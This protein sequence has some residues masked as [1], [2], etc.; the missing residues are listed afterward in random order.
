M[1]NIFQ[2]LVG[3]GGGEYTNI[4][5]LLYYFLSFDKHF[6]Y[7]IL[8]MRMYKTKPVDFEVALN[9]FEIDAH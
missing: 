2:Q 1:I 9:L 6:Y 7:L 8:A 3:G 4:I 5:I